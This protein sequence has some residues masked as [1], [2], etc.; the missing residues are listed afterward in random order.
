MNKYSYVNM[1]KCMIAQCRCEI[2]ID[3]IYINKNYID[4]ICAICG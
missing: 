3:K 4:R 1:N 2:Y